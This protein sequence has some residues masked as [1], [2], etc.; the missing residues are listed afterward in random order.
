M[1]DLRSTQR[2]QVVG[3]LWEI[4]CVVWLGGFICDIGICCS[5]T[6][7]LWGAAEGLKLAW[8]MGYKKKSFES[9]SQVLVEML[10][11]GGECS[12]QDKALV[13]L[14]RKLMAA[15]WDVVARDCY[16]EANK[17]ADWL[18]SANFTYELGLTIF[19]DPPT[20]LSQLV[21]ADI[22]RVSSPE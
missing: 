17:C 9:D 15:E 19:T 18:A 21:F 1:E 20:D 11:T 12:V 22:S 5:M 4:I 16:R 13:A 6:T 14:C 7:E 10:N 8:H 2:V 3:G